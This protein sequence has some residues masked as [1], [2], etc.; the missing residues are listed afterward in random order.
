MRV[1]GACSIGGVGHLQP[2]V[3]L[4]RAAETSGHDVRVMAPPSMRDAVT[5][6]GFAHAN[7]GSPDDDVIALIR[8]QLP[9]VSAAEASVLGNREMFGRIATASML[10]AMREVCADWQPDLI[11]RDPAEYA[12]AIVAVE[13]GVRA[14]QVACSLASVEWGSILVAAPAL[15]NHRW[16]L[17]DVVQSMEYLSAF[18][19]RIDPPEFSSTVRFHE[20]C[21]HV[22]EAMP[23]WWSG[24]QA[25]LVYLTLGTVTGQMS[26]AEGLYRTALEALAR[27]E[28]RVLLTV[29]TD[30]DLHR[31]RDM[32][33]NV[34]IERWIDQASVFPQ[35]DLVVC[36][37]GSGTVFG[38]LAA[39]VPVVV[40]PSFADQ[41]RN[42]DLVESHGLGAVVRAGSSPR[43]GS[44]TVLDAGDIE[45]IADAVRRVLDDDAYCER[46]RSIATEMQSTMT[47]V[48][49]IG[50]LI[51]A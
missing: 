37:G 39:G 44:R 30:F 33:P 34:H 45:R 1:L 42:G 21:P 38:A 9:V 26:V 23:D 35:A 48:E 24:S 20:P 29:G 25:P 15:E 40:L 12:S 2:L 47:P 49:V 4:L 31:L 43:D 8:E 28:V 27:L 18:P 17:V 19:A 41:F 7:G 14:A 13:L 6:D 36:H 16:G 46:A 11:L 5:R 10:P 22:A 32:P 51:G 50:H 3:P